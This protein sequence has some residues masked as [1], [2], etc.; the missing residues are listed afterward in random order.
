MSARTMFHVRLPLWAPGFVLVAIL[1]CGGDS[2]PSGQSSEPQGGPRLEGGS[3]GRGDLPTIQRAP[4]RG[5]VAGGGGEIDVDL[6][7]DVPIYPGAKIVMADERAGGGGVT[8]TFQTP[9]SPSDVFASLVKSFEAEGWSLQRND[10][11]ATK[12]FFADKESRSLSVFVQEKDGTTS[13]DVMILVL[14]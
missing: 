9:D 10:G 5:A 13:I 14:E 7:D 2:E 12:T 11:A 4:G 1:A 3:P 6:P 8:L